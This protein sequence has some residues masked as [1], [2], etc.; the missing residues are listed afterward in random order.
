MSIMLLANFLLLQTASAANSVSQYWINSGGTTCSGAPSYIDIYH[1]ENIYE[2]IDEKY[3]SSMSC[4]C[5]SSRSETYCYSSN[6]CSSDKIGTSFGSKSHVSVSKS[7]SILIN[8][9]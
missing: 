9:F 4:Y 5:S 8:H 6:S 2:N 1:Y 7:D 3:C